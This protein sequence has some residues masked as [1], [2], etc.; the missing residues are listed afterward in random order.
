MH[1]LHTQSK[2]HRGAIPLCGLS[3]YELD[4]EIRD[5]SESEDQT[6]AEGGRRQSSRNSRNK[7][8]RILLIT[9]AGERFVLE[10]M[11]AEERSTWIGELRVA[12]ATIAVRAS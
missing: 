9:A 2:K 5:R 1:A 7:V 10:A 4:N 3:I 11:S 6:V 8:N 12:V